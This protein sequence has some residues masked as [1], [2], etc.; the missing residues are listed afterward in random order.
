MY[1]GKLKQVRLSWDH[2]IPFSV[3][4][5]N[6]DDNWVASCKN[7]NSI[8]HANIFKTIGEARD[9]IQPRL[10]AHMSPLPEGVRDEA[11]P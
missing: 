11:C 1:K 7:C 2:F 5:D 9:H 6:P 4:L 10:F 3:I 8:K